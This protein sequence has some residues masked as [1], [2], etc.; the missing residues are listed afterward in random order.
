MN[1]ILLSPLALAWRSET[2]YLFVMKCI[3]DL[4]FSESKRKH[5]QCVTAGDVVRTVFTAWSLAA[6]DCEAR[7]KRPFLISRFGHKQ[8][9]ANLA[10]LFRQQKLLKVHMQL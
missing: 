8:Q 1:S 6:L 2:V 7:Y 10:F 9:F 3:A 4:H 5:T